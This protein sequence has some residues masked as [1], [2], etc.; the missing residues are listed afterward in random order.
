M[1]LLLAR[2]GET[3][4][5]ARGQIQGQSDPGLN[6]TGRAQARALARRLEETG[7]PLRRLYTSPQ[8][9]SA[10]TAAIVGACLG[11]E[12]EAV[13]GLRE[14]CFGVWEGHCW[15]EIAALWPH[16]YEAY[17]AD[18]LRSRPPE[19][20]SYAELLERVLPALRKIAAGEGSAL[21]VAHS[22]VIKAVLC[23]L[24]GA[25]FRQINRLYPLGNADWVSLDGD[26]FL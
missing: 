17:A 11:I 10:E 2:H 25:D 18:R 16:Y 21:V 13:E 7:V 9:R 20:E 6:E 12:A 26:R 14:I 1:K 8:K 24:D 23:H 19:G 5:N 22:A 4:W 3:D 15:E